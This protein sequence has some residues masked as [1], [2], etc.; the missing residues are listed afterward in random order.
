MNLFGHAWVSLFAGT[1]ALSLTLAVTVPLVVKMGPWSRNDMLAAEKHRNH[2]RSFKLKAPASRSTRLYNFAMSLQSQSTRDWLVLSLSNIRICN[3]FAKRDH[4]DSIFR[5]SVM[6]V[7]Y[8]RVGYLG[9]ERRPVGRSADSPRG[10]SLAG[11]RAGLF[12]FRLDLQNQTHSQHNLSMMS[13]SPM[14]SSLDTDN[15]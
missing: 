10:I 11:S 1:A 3:T 15:I 14:R 6:L 9:Q 12:T 2:C 5:V 8:K 13:A 7:K 4:S